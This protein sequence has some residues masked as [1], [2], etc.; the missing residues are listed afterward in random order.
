M[1]LED[2][3]ASRRKRSDGRPE[4]ARFPLM[5][6]TDF[7]RSVLR[8][9]LDQIIA[10]LNVIRLRLAT[11]R[12]ISR[13][14]DRDPLQERGRIGDDVEA[15][16]PDHPHKGLLEKIRRVVRADLARQIAEQIAFVV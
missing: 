14:I 7:R 1:K 16:V 10:E 13:E 4:K 12:E 5:F 6:D 8:G 2:F 9:R 11:A 15:L 3:A